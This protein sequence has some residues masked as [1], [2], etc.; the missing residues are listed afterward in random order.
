[1][2]QL[3]K[4]PCPHCAGQLFHCQLTGRKHA[5]RC[6]RCDAVI[7]P[8]KRSPRTSPPSRTPPG[9]SPL[10]EVAKWL[11]KEAPK[12]DYP[13]E[14]IKD[15]ARQVKHY[16]SLVGRAGNGHHRP[17]DCPACDRCNGLMFLRQSKKDWF[18]TSCRSVKK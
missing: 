2:P 3:L 11:K 5:Y 14:I 9:V 8:P 1:M 18:C 13:P 4:K 15:L 16:R 12:P 17:P 10:L 6:L 7:M